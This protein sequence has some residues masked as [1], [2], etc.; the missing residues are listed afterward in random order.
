MIHGEFVVNCTCEQRG[1]SGSLTSCVGKGPGD[2]PNIITYHLDDSKTGSGIYIRK[3][4]D[5]TYN[6]VTS[7]VETGVRSQQGHVAVNDKSSNRDVLP[8]SK[9]GNQWERLW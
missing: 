7:S 8:Y 1:M 4:K 2:V 9:Y 6:N 3:D 5:M